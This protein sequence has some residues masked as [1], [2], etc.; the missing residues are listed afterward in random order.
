MTATGL[1]RISK[2]GAFAAQAVEAQ[3]DTIVS[4]PDQAWQTIIMPIETIDHA[5]QM[6]LGIGPE[7]EVIAPPALRQRVRELAFQCCQLH[8]DKCNQ[9]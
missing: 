4:G 9:D 8:E 2:L 3:R 7:L 1:D 5:A 6:L